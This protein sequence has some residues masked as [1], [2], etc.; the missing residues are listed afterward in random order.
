MATY[1]MELRKIQAEFYNAMQSYPI[2]DESYREQLNDKIYHALKYREIGYET[3]ELFLEEL[4]EWMNLNM[5]EYNWLYKA[6]LIELTPLQRAKLLQIYNGTSNSKENS[7]KTGNDRKVSNENQSTSNTNETSLNETSG[8]ND[9]S[10]DNTTS[11]QTSTDKGTTKST[12]NLSK[13]YQ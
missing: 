1:T 5:P 8:V 7:V 3:P 10:N 12:D 9:N 13:K 2:F 4:E 6:N 11:T